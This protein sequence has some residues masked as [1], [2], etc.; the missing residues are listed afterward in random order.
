MKTTYSSAR[1]RA[2]LANRF[3]LISLYDMAEFKCFEQ[4]R[5]VWESPDISSLIYETLL[6]LQIRA[7]MFNYKSHFS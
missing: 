7:G 3:L 1:N 5:D 4:N 2:I 6:F